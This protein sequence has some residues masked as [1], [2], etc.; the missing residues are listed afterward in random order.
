MKQTL[1][2]TIALL[3]FTAF[4]QKTAEDYFNLGKPIATNINNYITVAS[5]TNKDVQNSAIGNKSESDQSKAIAD[6]KKAVEYF[7]KALELKPNYAEAYYLRG[8]CL[9]A[10]LDKKGA[11]EDFNKAIEL[12]SKY[13]EAYGIRGNLKSDEGDKEGACLDWNEALKLGGL[14]AGQKKGIKRRIQ[15]NGCK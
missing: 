3:S 5:A 1:I 2:V 15:M 7:D 14:D 10:L 6:F 13:G 12:D 8:R 11:M 9:L 4:G